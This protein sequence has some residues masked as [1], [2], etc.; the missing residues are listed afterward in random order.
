[1]ERRTVID[2]MDVFYRIYKTNDGDDFI[3]II[4]ELEE[5]IFDQLSQGCVPYNLT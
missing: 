2:H 4:E 3:D 5:K 1:M